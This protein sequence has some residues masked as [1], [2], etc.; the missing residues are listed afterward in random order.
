[1]KEIKKKK[2]GSIRSKD[3]LN[4]STC[5]FSSSV[6]L[7]PNPIKTRYVI[8]FNLLQYVNNLIN[9]LKWSIDK[10]ENDQEIKSE[11][12]GDF[13]LESPSK[14]FKAL[15]TSTGLFQIQVYQF[16]VKNIFYYKLTWKKN[17]IVVFQWHQSLGDQTRSME[18]RQNM[19]QSKN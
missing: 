6:I 14:S 1:M 16:I 13:Y 8:Y 18:Q 5:N 12:P 4:N 15:F 11:N 19:L 7:L 2:D 17:M 10:L 3:K 9:E